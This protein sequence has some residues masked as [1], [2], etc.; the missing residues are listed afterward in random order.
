MCK[1]TYLLTAASEDSPEQGHCS[2]RHRQ[3]HVGFMIGLPIFP[4]VHEDKKNRNVSEDCRGHD[5]NKG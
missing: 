2:I 4:F 3:I 1:K 5:T